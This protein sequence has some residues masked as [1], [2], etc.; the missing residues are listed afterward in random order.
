M[1]EIPLPGLSFSDPRL[2]MGTMAAVFTMEVEWS[3]EREQ[4]AV[5]E[6]RR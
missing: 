5:V 2:G 3:N 1:R 6:K 4:F